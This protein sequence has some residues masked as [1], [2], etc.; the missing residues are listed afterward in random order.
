MTIPRLIIGSAVLLAACAGHRPPKA[1]ALPPAGD[2]SITSQKHD[3]LSGWFHIVWGDGTRYFLA[4]G[5]GQTVELLLRPP[6]FESTVDPLT[7]DRK[8]V[9]AIG[10]WSTPASRM[11][12]VV[13]LRAIPQ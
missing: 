13:K 11:M 1:E 8:R 10:F 6:V 7:F 9:E 4:A 2:A 5:S 12:H 3:T